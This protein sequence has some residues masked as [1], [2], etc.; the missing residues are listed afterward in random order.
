MSRGYNSRRKVKRQE[1]RSTARSA[2]RRRR[3]FPPRL[4]AV[5]PVLVIASILAIVGLVGFSTSSGLSRQ[6]VEAEVSALLDG[7]PQR[8]SVLG[9]PRAPLTVRVYGDLEC[10]TVKLFVENYLPSIIDGWVRTGA[11]R[12]D[13]RSL[14]TDTSDEEVFFKQEIAALAAGR[15]NRMWNFALT[16]A[17]EQGEPR[18]DYVT[19]A[20]IQGIASQVPELDTA[21]WQSDRADAR[22]SK[23]VALG[24]YEGHRSDI[25]YTPSLLISFTKGPVDRKAGRDAL[26]QELEIFLKDA[27]AS[28]KHEA[29]E[30]FPALRTANSNSGGG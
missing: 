18:T 16:F 20:F 5:V 30:D 21:R 13:Y 10:P 11:V 24:V 3:T 4:L 29:S 27:L 26:L 8:G 7:I 15:Q 17:R 25:R 2:P 28:L 14:K 19:G 9:S 12:L 23:R 6:Q 1:A 22:L